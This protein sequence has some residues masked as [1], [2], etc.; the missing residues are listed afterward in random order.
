MATGITVVGTSMY[1]DHQTAPP[2]FAN[3]VPADM[4][5]APA[6]QPPCPEVPRGSTSDRECTVAR[7]TCSVKRHLAMISNLGIEG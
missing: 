7:N 5:W 2:G 1:H 4:D 3:S 6:C